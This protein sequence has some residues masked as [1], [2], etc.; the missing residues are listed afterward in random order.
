MPLSAQQQRERRAAKRAA[1]AQ[2]AARGQRKRRRRQPAGC[3]LDPRTGEVTGTWRKL[4]TDEA[5]D[6]PSF[7][8]TM[9]CNP[10]WDEITRSLNTG[11]MPRDRPDLLARVFKLKLDALLKELYRDGILAARSRTCTSSSSRSAGC[12]TRIS[13]S[14]SR[15]RIGCTRPSKSTHA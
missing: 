2:D 8:I 5:V 15:R 12:R 9:T 3:S 10:K 13:S 14:S 11:E 6:K 7:F 4:L 1:E